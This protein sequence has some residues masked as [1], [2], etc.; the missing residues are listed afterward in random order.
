MQSIISVVLSGGAGT[1]L[2]PASREGHPKPFMKMGDGQTL[3]KKTY[4]RAKSLNSEI[5]TVTNR[6]YYF[7]SRDEIGLAGAE[8]GFLLEP[9]G[10][11]TA[12]AIAVAAKVVECL[13]GND[14]LM[15]VLAADHLIEDQILFEKSVREATELATKDFLVTFG[16][17]PTSPETGYGYIECGE[18]LNLG[19]KVNRFVEKPNLET[20]REYVDSG[21]YLWNSGMF[22]FKAGVFLTELAKHA[23]E[24]FNATEDC[25]KLMQPVKD[26]EMLEIPKEFNLIPDISVDY[27]LMEKSDKVAVVHGDFGWSDIGSWGAIRDL[28]EPDSDQNRA[29]GETIFVDSTNTFV[30]SEDRLVA[31]VGVKDLIIIDTVDALLVAHPDKTQ[32]VKK[33]VARLK[34]ENND[35]FKLHRTVLRPW[36]SYTVLEESKNFK[37]K[38]IEVRPGASLSLQMHHHR[39]EHW[40]VVTGIARITN[41]ENDMLIRANE[42]TYIPAGQK[43]RLENPGDVPCVMIEVQCGQYLGEDD[44]VRFE[45]K[46]GR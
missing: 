11:N 20:A 9:F 18:S 10:R 44:I 30:Q 3:I 41:G 1:R 42:S 5:L 46:Y 28:V 24:V 32:D 37:I 39:S 34:S 4:E 23:P 16:I 19:N 7:M 21:K 12:P 38:R 36:G 45:D 40:V 2:W 15:L 17:V 27:A 14:A 43:H 33:V 22:C 25:W 8:G 6:D 31:T 13:R 26:I 29:I 35:A